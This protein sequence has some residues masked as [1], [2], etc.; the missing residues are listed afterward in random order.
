MKLSAPI[1][2][3]KRQAKRIARDEKIPLHAAL[4]R[5]AAQEGERGWSALA[6]KVVPTRKAEIFSRLAPGDML[7]IGARP[8]RGKTLLAL[9]LAIDAVKSGRRATFFTLEYTEKD[10]QDRFRALGAERMCFDQLFAADCSDQIN[11][12][13]VIAALASAERGTLAVIDY[14]Q[15]LDQKRSNPDLETQVRALRIFA[16]ET[17]VIIVCISQIDRAYDASKKP[18]PDIRDIRLP[19]PLDLKL[20]DKMCFLNEGRA[21]FEAMY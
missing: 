17:G 13:H 14:L 20:F 6:A 3:L 12:D 1:Y 5:I 16:R 15:L 4:D 21:Q 10:V 18:M 11:A 7:L 2:H 9:E 19:N 8:G